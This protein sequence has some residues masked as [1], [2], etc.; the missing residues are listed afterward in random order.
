MFLI[1]FLPSHFSI[2]PF[3]LTD[4]KSKVGPA[5]GQHLQWR[6]E[7]H[8][9]S[10]DQPELHRHPRDRPQDAGAIVASQGT[11]VRAGETPGQHCF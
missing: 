10:L 4:D 7:E 2:P 1:L 11:R 9:H 6:S 5:G 3:F 8:H